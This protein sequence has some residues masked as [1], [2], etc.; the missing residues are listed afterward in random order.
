MEPW[1]EE[2]VDGAQVERVRHDLPAVEHEVYLNNGTFGPVPR[3][4]SEAMQ[5]VLARELAEGRIA[6]DYFARS[7][8]LREEARS[9]LA[10][11]FG[12]QAD[13]IALTPRTTDGIDIALWGMP[14]QRG[15]EILT[16]R[17]EHPGLLLPLAALSR[18]TGARVSFVETPEH[19]TPRAW[20]NAFTARQ[21]E[22]TRAIAFSHVLWTQG[23]LLPLDDLCAFA[24]R[25]GLVSI[26]DGA[27]AAGAVPVDLHRS[28]V[29]FYALPGQKWLQAPEGT[30]A[31]YVAASRQ[32]QCQ[33]TFVGYASGSALDAN[34]THFQP[35]QG[36]R[37]YEIGSPSQAS[38]AGLVASLRWQGAQNIA[39]LEQRIGALARWLTLALGA[40]DGVEVVTRLQERMSGL[41]SFRVHGASAEDVA[42]ALGSRGF[43][44][45]H[46]PAPHAAVRVSCGFYT[47]GDEVG[48]LVDAIGEIA[49][50]L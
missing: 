27:Q 31:L 24:R 6:P 25:E 29:D 15:A 35:S 8:A 32:T 36:A 20:L 10:A 45:R 12:A 34:A 33:A 19:P 47:T 18:R 28:G 37:R 22:Q 43:R 3:P 4:S 44:V 49:S 9:L 41:V 30:G 39:W 7:G 42:A 21:T 38:L 11:R 40:V 5:A 17:E 46:L 26:V 16:T 23:D 1:R 48:R 13:E 14:W 2:D 50:S